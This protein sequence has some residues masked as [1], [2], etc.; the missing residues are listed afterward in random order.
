MLKGQVV[1]STSYHDASFSRRPRADRARVDH[2]G[3]GEDATARPHYQRLSSPLL[4]PEEWQEIAAEYQ[5]EAAGAITRLS[6]D[7][8]RASLVIALR[9]IGQLWADKQ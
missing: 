2:S 6:S 3:S 4:D 9:T 7:A 8:G 1:L 5:R